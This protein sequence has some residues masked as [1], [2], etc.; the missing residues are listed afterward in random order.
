MKPFLFIITL[1]VWSILN[2]SSVAQTGSVSPFSRYG[3]GEIEYSL[4]ARYLGMGGC[5]LSHSNDSGDVVRTMNLSNP[6]ALSTMGVSSIN[7]GLDAKWYSI[8]DVGR[9]HKAFQGGFNQLAIGFP[10]YISKKNPQ[11][12]FE[13]IGMAFGLKPF[14]RIGYNLA[15]VNIQ[16]KDTTKYEGTGG[17]SSS[18]IGLGIRPSR[19]FS[20]G[21]NI[22]YTWGNSEHHRYFYP[23][24]DSSLINIGS[25]HLDNY[26]GFNYTFGVQSEIPL[27]KRNSLK[28][29]AIIEPNVFLNNAQT[30]YFYNFRLF[31]GAPLVRDT[32]LYNRNNKDKLALPFAIGGGISF[33]NRNRFLLSSDVYYQK[34]SDINENNITQ[35]DRIRIAIGGEWVT[36]GKD[37]SGLAK[38]LN[39]TTLRM[40]GFYDR[41]PIIIGNHPVIEYG[42]TAG[43]GLKLREM[44]KFLPPSQLNL[45]LQIG[46]KGKLPETAIRENNTRLMIELI[47][48]D[49]WF[50]KRKYD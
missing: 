25:S 40:G 22:S 19:Y 49:K 34:W 15:Q 42:F 33:V 30:I 47:I 35:N 6:A 31:G 16:S 27:S 11:R 32:I 7:A 39:G 50:N 44:F 21:V 29:G 5:V 24:P 9:Q 46:T 23:N 13:V 41:L 12:P 48:N 10:I 3:Y 14:S 2:Q 20:F 43:I 18:F 37:K 28:L 17:G 26:T 8:N 1:V 38:T 36:A 45:G 4:Q